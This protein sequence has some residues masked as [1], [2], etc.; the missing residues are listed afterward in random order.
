MRSSYIV[1]MMK[2]SMTLLCLAALVYAIWAC[3]TGVEPGTTFSHVLKIAGS[4]VLVGTIVFFC[5]IKPKSG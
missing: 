5:W 4:V 3:V 2:S 1:I